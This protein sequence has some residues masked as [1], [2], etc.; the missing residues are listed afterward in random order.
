MMGTVNSNIVRV[1]SGWY[2]TGN[3]QIRFQS[4]QQLVLLTN[5]TENHVSVK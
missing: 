1:I 5:I 2:Y 3:L 4:L